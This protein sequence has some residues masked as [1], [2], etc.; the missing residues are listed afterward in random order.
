[1]E[2]PSPIN[3]TAS[4]VVESVMVSWPCPQSNTVPAGIE[5]C[6]APERVPVMPR[7]SQTLEE[8]AAAA[9]Q[10]LSFAPASAPAKRSAFCTRFSEFTAAEPFT[11]RF[12]CGLVVLT[13]S[14]VG[15]KRCDDCIK[16]IGNV[17]SQQ[18]LKPVSVKLVVEAPETKILRGEL[19]KLGVV[20]RKTQ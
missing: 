10:A 11:S 7:A 9:R 2:E 18:P 17:E 3:S 19:L 6:A 13:P 15:V 1:M 20:L 16:L 4:F 12:D 5:M 14:D 8:L